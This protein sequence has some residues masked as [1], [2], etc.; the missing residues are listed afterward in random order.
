MCGGERRPTGATVAAY[1]YNAGAENTQM[2]RI[3]AV[4]GL[5]AEVKAFVDSD[6]WVDLLAVFRRQ[7]LTGSAVGLKSVAPLC[8]FT[9][10]VEDP[11][12]GES[13]IRYDQAV[14]QADPA[15]SLAARDWLL[16]YNRN[17]VEATAALRLWLEA[18]ASRFPT[19]AELEL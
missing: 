13:M 7:L 17:D 18:D 15:A 6:E 11:G 9:W 3:A 5:E 2:R 12:G 8:E 10:E 4:A 16:T 1:C 19:V 14:D